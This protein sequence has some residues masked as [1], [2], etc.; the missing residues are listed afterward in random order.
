MVNGRYERS[1]FGRILF[2]FL[3]VFMLL[4]PY[5]EVLANSAPIN[6]PEP[7]GVLIPKKD[8]PIIVQEEKL[9]FVLQDGFAPAEVT[10]E[11]TFYNPTNEVVEEILA[12]PFHSFGNG[13]NIQISIDGELLSDEMIEIEQER[14]RYEDFLKE[15]GANG[16]TY[17][18][19][20]TGSKN[21]DWKNYDMIEL[22][23]IATFPVIFPPASKVIV[24]LQYKQS[25]G[26]DDHQYINDVYIYEYLLQ[27]ATVWKEFHNLSINI[28]VP[29]DSYFASNLNFT[30]N[31]HLVPSSK[32]FDKNKYDIYSATY[33]TLPDENL[34]FSYMSKKGL[35]G[36]IVDKSSYDFIA[37]LFLFFIA[38]LLLLLVVYLMTRVNK[39][40][41]HWLIG[42]IASVFS[43]SFIVLFTY[44][45]FVELFPIFANGEWLGGYGF[46]IT[47]L[48]LVLYIAIM[49]FPYVFIA[50]FIKKRRNK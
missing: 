23:T 3:L 10:V 1:V 35:I 28:L 34:T 6:Q 14:E 41:I 22:S 31:N 46:I 16:Y 48:L 29:K 50:L 45:I 5:G 20:I 42:P 21:K 15:F 19:P 17:I 43:V 27:P 18:D 33:A 44:L 9:Q 12:F 38:T 2:S 24:R 8:T 32:T 36:N 47:Y 39:W 30:I 13:E 11:Y 40:W 7:T 37:F 25:F 26:M 49:Y 4:V